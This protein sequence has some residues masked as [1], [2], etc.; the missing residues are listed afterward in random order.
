MIELDFLLISLG[1]IGRYDNA[2][3]KPSLLSHMKLNILLENEVMQDKLHWQKV[4]KQIET[5]ILTVL[6]IISSNII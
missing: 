6:N 3:A 1:Y 4:W 5:C 2:I